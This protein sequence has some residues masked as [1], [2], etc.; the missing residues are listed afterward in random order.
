METQSPLEGEPL[1]IGLYLAWWME[2]GIC[3]LTDLSLPL[4]T[5]LALDKLPTPKALTSS[6]VKWDNNR[7]RLEGEMRYCVQR[8]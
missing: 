2:N 8:A 5:S 4:A 1:C 7:L 6:S 3:S